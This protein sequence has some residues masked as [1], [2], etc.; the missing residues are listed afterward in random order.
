MKKITVLIPCHNEEKGISKVIREI[1]TEH[2]LKLGFETQVVVID[3]NSTDSTRQVAMQKKGV[4]VVHEPRLGKGNALRAGL[5]AVSDD[6]DYVV[7]LD[8]DSTYN[9]KEIPR[10][11]EPLESRFC[12]VIVGSR[13]G[14]KTHQGSLKAANRIVNWSFTF[15]V[16]HLYRA[17]VTDVLSG[18]FA[19][20][21]NV[22]MDLAPHLH[23]RGF[24]IEMEMITKMVRLNHEIYSVPITYNIRAGNS[25]ISAIPD[26]LKILYMLFL[27]LSWSPEKSRFYKKLRFSI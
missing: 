5:K 9:P 22:I 19:W 14:G 7:M 8:G 1:P 6:T 24:A 17:N 18:F 11:V 4:R 3:N 23:S 2:L 26:A 13:L 27:N 20:K 15:L 10:L 16:R 25:K 12:D 21:R